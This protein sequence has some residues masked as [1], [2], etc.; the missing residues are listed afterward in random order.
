[1]YGVFTVLERWAFLTFF[2][3]HPQM[4]FVERNQEIQTVVLGN[5]ILRSDRPGSTAFGLLEGEPLDFTRPASSAD[6]ASFRETNRLRARPRG[7]SVGPRK[8][9]GRYGWTRAED[10]SMR[11]GASTDGGVRRRRLSR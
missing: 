7:P 11:R 9:T 4:A 1:M 2:D 3:D 8:G 5:H 6:N 10:A